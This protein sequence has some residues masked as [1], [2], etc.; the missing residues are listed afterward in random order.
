M[1]VLI[2]FVWVGTLWGVVHYLMKLQKLKMSKDE[3][4]FL[5]DEE[6]AQKEYNTARVIIWGTAYV[7]MMII[8][9]VYSCNTHYYIM[10]K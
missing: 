3:W 10:G 4:G 9:T 8:F 7:V 6:E 5:T 2:F 1:G